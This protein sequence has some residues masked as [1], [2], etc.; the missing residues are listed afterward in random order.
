MS[1]EVQI[2]V[3]SLNYDH[4]AIMDELKTVLLNPCFFNR[5]K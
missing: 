4:V 1:H 3:N 2:R 5:P